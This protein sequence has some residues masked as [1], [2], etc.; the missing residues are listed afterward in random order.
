MREDTFGGVFA[1]IDTST[2]H[3][4]PIIPTIFASFVL[5]LCFKS[6]IEKMNSFKIS[7]SNLI[8]NISMIFM[9][10]YFFGKYTEFLYFN[11]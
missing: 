5:V 6:S 2:L 11:F 4:I 8:L 9:T 1:N 7:Y 3:V 10:F